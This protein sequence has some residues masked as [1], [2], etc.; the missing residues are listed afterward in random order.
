MGLVGDL[1]KSGVEG[2]IG[3]SGDIIDKFVT[4]PEQKLEAKKMLMNA[5]LEA[6]KLEIES[7]NKIREFALQY[8]GT[9]TQ[10]PKW[11]LVLRSLIRPLISILL[12]ASLMFFIGSDIFIKTDW[13]NE[14]PPQYWTILNI[15]LGFW[16]GG[17]MLENTVEKF[18]NTKN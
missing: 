6:K 8:E 4:T 13:L 16:F 11:I 18:K 10:V 17:K 1:F 5:E 2:V 9:A 14:L 15:V 12:F 3:A 7:S